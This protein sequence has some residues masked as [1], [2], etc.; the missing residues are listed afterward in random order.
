MAR[1]DELATLSC[2]AHTLTR[3]AY[4]PAMRAA[5]NRVSSWM[6][7]A[8]MTVYEDA[9]GNL[10]GSYPANRSA[11]RTLII[12]A[13]LDTVRDAG[14]YNGSLGLLVAIAAVE[15]LHRQERRLAAAIDVVAFANTEG[16]R[17]APAC[18]G[19]LA[20]TGQLPKDALYAQ[21]ETGVSLEAAIRE[22]GGDPEHLAQDA[23]RPED[24]LG[25]LE[26]QIGPTLEAQGQP[27]GLVTAIA[28]AT[29]AQLTLRGT[30]GHAGA[31]PMNLRH[32]ALAG[33]AQLILAAEKIAQTT[34]GLVATIGQ[35]A[36]H[37]NAHN[38][39]PG[40]V[41]LSL[42]LRHPDDDLR[43][44]ALNDLQERAMALAQQRGLQLTWEEVQSH[45]A[46]TLTPTFCAR[47]QQAIES[48]GCTP[49]ALTSGTLH[50][51]AILATFT[52]SAMLLVPSRSGLSHQP[53]EAVAPEAVAAAIAAV[54]RFLESL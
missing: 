4:M 10:V 49:V 24:L 44:Q 32:D 51:A 27:L 42:D 9:A 30:A 28:G 22:F 45:P 52:N 36:L 16:L 38:V 25:Y 14:R 1:C 19:S 41:R 43:L 39:I 48:A 6:R 12:G 34:P 31:L 35:L 47:L 11:A 18:T 54:G 53:S 21:D 3:P 26:V 50:D 17:F 37:P 7:A 8:G 2:D 40:Q 5:H 46:C 15:A 29:H 23:R 13:H 20:L 33:A